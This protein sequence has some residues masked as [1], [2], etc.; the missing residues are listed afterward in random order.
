MKPVLVARS[1]YRPVTIL[2]LAILFALLETLTYLVAFGPLASLNVLLLAVALAT[3]VH[4]TVAG[5]IKIGLYPEFAA[6][7]MF[8]VAVTLSRQE[9]INA[10][11]AGAIYRR[12]IS[13]LALFVLAGL[14]L[15]TLTSMRGL[16]V[17]MLITALFLS[18][19][20]LIQSMASDNF[21][22]AKDG[23]DENEYGVMCVALAPACF[24]LTHLSSS[25][26]SKVV[27]IAAIALIGITVV[28]TASR[29]AMLLYCLAIAMLVRWKQIRPRTIL[30][31]L[32][33]AIL[34]LPLLPKQNLSRLIVLPGIESTV[35]KKDDPYAEKSY[36]LR[37]EVW[38]HALTEVVPA[39]LALGV[40]L[41][42][43]SYRSLGGVSAH[44]MYLS[45]LGEHGVIGLLGFLSII[46]AALTRYRHAIHVAIQ[47]NSTQ[48]LILSRNLF[49]SLVLLLIGGMTLTIE[50]RLK[51]MWIL[52]GVPLGLKNVI[53]SEVAE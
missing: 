12:I 7:L 37:V 1:L 52:L 3:L 17:I 21:R 13:D 18:V 25:R 23:W 26:L 2:Y 6:L 41:G 51:L 9:A 16:L 22:V 50:F 28:L 34:A 4:L 29:T 53:K 31:G 43:W 42:N 40:G 46:A 35:D 36:L 5:R 19:D 39:N 20:L 8:F 24:A 45:V 32:F 47:C 33:M 44:N 38:R 48:S 14:M 30:I 15:Q 10:V 49:L 27:S 11:A